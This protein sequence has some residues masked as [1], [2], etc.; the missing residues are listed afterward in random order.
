MSHF[1]WSQRATWQEAQTGPRGIIGSSTAATSSRHQRSLLP[2][3]S[4]FMIHGRRPLAP[5][6]RYPNFMLDASGNF[7]FLLK[8][9]ERKSFKWKLIKCLYLSTICWDDQV[10][11]C[12]SLVNESDPWWRGSSCVALRTCSHP[13]PSNPRLRASGT[14]GNRSD[15]PENIF[16]VCV[17]KCVSRVVRCL[18]LWTPHYSNMKKPTTVWLSIHPSI[19]P[20]IY[21]LMAYQN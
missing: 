12:V 13:L 17:C 7:L 5:P 20:S 16:T 18:T 4:S 8:S 9:V 11:F 3:A 14:S 2:A 15:R 1:D 10:E 19:H 6:S 21:P